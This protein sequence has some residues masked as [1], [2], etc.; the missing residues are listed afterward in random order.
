MSGVPVKELSCPEYVAAMNGLMA[1]LMRALM[2]AGDPVLGMIQQTTV[3]HVPDGDAD[4]EAA[5]GVMR[6]VEIATT[7]N[8][9]FDA[10]L[11]TDV[12]AWSAMMYEAAQQA[13]AET[14]PQV[15]E[16]M[17][18]AISKGGNVVDAKGRPF[19][20]DVYLDALDMV[21]LD[22]DDEGKPKLQ[23]LVVHP[24]VLERIKNLPFTD[25]QKARG[26]AII[27]RKKLEFDARRRV[28]KLG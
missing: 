23:T 9:K 3:D 10:I 5:V 8:L 26:D 18:D 7:F 15:F 20:W 17:K 16:G 19:D 6:S 1:E 2:T 28:R 24:D 11:T 21:E 4:P 27:A 22:F 12:D 13:L 14:M 25:E